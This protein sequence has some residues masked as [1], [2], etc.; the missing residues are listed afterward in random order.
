LAIRTLVQFIFAPEI[1][2]GYKRQKN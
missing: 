1:G 2:E